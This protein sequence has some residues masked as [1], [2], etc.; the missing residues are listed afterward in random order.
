MYLSGVG[1]L[2]CCC[3][4]FVFFRSLL[5]EFVCVHTHNGAAADD[6]FARIWRQKRL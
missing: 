3:I 6:C 1:W 5:E 2:L 4:L